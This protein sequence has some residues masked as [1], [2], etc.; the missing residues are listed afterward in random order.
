MSNVVPA[1]MAE[2]R[3]TLPGTVHT[4]VA[5]RDDPTVDIFV[6]KS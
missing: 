3:P 5:D 4:A 2:P 6:D 1:K